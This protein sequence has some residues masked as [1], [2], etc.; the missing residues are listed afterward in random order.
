MPTLNLA[1]FVDV[2]RYGRFRHHQ[3]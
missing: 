3:Q 1:N 2:T